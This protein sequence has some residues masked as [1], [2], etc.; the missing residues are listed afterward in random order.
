MRITPPSPA[1]RTA[2]AT[3]VRA[4][5][6]EVEPTRTPVTRTEIRAALARAHQEMTGHAATPALLDTL[7]AQASLETAG[8]AKMYNYN[9]GGIKGQGP[10]GLTAKCRTFEVEGGKQVHI[11]DG[12]RAYTSL[13]EGAKDYL[14]LMRG[15]FKS[16]LAKAETGDVRGFAHELH[17]AHYYTAS[18]ADYAAALGAPAASGGSRG[19]PPTASLGPPRGLGPPPDPLIPS[20]MLSASQLTRILDAV[21]ASVAQIGAPTDPGGERDG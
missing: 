7:T 8:G 16:A 6:R 15:Q 4:A 3:S 18:E 17:E 1:P 9:F 19:S 11:R 14:G 13:D 10:S 20:E 5:A 21:S 12:F 2:P